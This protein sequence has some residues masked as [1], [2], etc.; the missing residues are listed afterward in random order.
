MERKQV[1]LAPSEC[2]HRLAW[3]EEHANDVDF[4]EEFE[5]KYGDMIPKFSGESR[6]PEREAELTV[7][8]AAWDK[9]MR[10]LPP[11]PDAAR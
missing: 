1:V 7:M 2:T 5:A 11:C 10:S 3:E 8:I 4:F 9:H 6:T